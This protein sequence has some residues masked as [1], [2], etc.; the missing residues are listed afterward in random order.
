MLKTWAKADAGLPQVV[1]AKAWM[2]EHGGVAA[3]E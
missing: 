3:G 2:G 1:A